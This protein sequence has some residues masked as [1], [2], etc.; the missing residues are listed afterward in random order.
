MLLQAASVIGRQFDPDLLAAVD[1]GTDAREGLAEMDE[2]SNAPPIYEEGKEG[3]E[4]D[5]NASQF[6]A[7]FQERANALNNCCHLRPPKN[8]G[9]RVGS[10]A[11]AVEC[12]W[13]IR[14]ISN[15]V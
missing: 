7:C 4:K 13:P 2:Q 8:I 14:T 5:R 1:G 11:K 10:G 15:V 9:D 6:A 3:G 12:V